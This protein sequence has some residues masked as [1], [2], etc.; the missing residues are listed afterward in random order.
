M[1]KLKTVSRM[2]AAGAFAML[3]SAA[4]PPSFAHAQTILGG[5]LKDCTEIAQDDYYC[6]VDKLLAPSDTSDAEV[7]RCIIPSLLSVPIPIVVKCS[8]AQTKEFL[9][10][11][12]ETKEKY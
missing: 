12:T 6:C 11:I 3:V 5:D 9:A 7:S 2:F 1:K 4:V 10:C 8:V